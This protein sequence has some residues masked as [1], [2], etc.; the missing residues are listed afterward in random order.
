MQISQLT[1]SLINI[2]STEESFLSEAQKLAAFFRKTEEYSDPGLIM[3]EFFEMADSKV[4]E[5]TL[6]SLLEITRSDIDLIND[7][8]RFK[9][10]ERLVRRHSS[11]PDTLSVKEKEI[12]SGLTS[13]IP[14]SKAQ[15]IDIVR[16]VTKDWIEALLN[17]TGIEEENNRELIFLFRSESQILKARLELLPE[18]INPYSMKAVTRL[19]PFLT[20]GE[21]SANSIDELCTAME[22][23]KQLGEPVL[24]FEIAMKPEGFKKWLKKIANDNALTTLTEMLTLQREKLIP[25][26]RLT[27]V[28]TIIRGLLGNDAK[29]PD[30][31]SQSLQCTNHSGFMIEGYKN[32]YRVS[33]YLAN[34]G[35]EISDNSLSGNFNKTSLTGL[36]GADMLT[37]QLGS[38]N[39]LSVRDL[40]KS[41]MHNDLLMCRLLGDPKVYNSPGIVE[42]IVQTSRSPAVLTKIASSRELYTGQANNRVPLSLLKNPTNIPITLL[43]QFINP[44]Y[45]SLADMRELLRYPFGIRSEVYGEVKAYVE[46]RR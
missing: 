18:K 43:R 1:E 11:F 28:A 26:R 32:L 15:D 29:S 23:N 14:L 36:I 31:I 42:K 37:R 46:R 6:F 24:A 25:L 4:I 5:H 33:R 12:F 30:W 38:Q 40:V 41:C 10:L 3:R 7:C 19:L 34:C 2:L 17:G 8:L 16:Q 22:Q 39:E 44:W 20:I 13:E 27:A 21:E 45:V 35:I 9:Q